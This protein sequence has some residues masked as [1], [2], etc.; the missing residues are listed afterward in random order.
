MFH[1][2]GL[3]GRSAWVGQ[4][5]L[6]PVRPVERSRAVDSPMPGEAALQPSAQRTSALHAY[7]GERGDTP[8]PSRRVRLAGEVMARPAICLG[9]EAPLGE[10]WGELE[11]RA[12]RQLLV[13]DAKG[14]LVGLVSRHDLLGPAWPTLLGEHLAGGAAAADLGNARLLAA[15]QRGLQSWRELNSRTAGQL[16]RSP[17]PAAQADT[18]LRRIAAVL[19]ETGLPGV[20]VVDAQ[21]HPLGWVGRRELLFAVGT[22]PPLDLWG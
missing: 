4:D 15:M 12:V 8:A 13:T 1:V 21:G 20:P 6:E 5:L 2:Y 9:I 11:R 22:D 14:A 18:E 16:L 19:V 10:I 17:I 3:S 7:A